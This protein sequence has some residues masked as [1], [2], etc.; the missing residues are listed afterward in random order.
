MSKFSIK[1]GCENPA[2]FYGNASKYGPEFY[3]ILINS[4]EVQ[5][6]TIYPSNFL[7]KVEDLKEGDADFTC[8]DV[9]V[10]RVTFM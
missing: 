8:N 9:L 1:N 5:Y 4:G 2:I 3:D 7:N 10:Y 6:G